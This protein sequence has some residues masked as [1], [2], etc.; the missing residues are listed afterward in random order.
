MT[1]PITEP[2]K[3]GRPK[4][5]KNIRPPKPTRSPL[6][7]TLAKMDVNEYS[8]LEGSFD[9]VRQVQSRC[10]VN[11]SR[12]PPEMHGK[13]FATSVFTAISATDAQEVIYLIRIWRIE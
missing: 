6:Y 2:R 4:G 12:R 11:D 1:Q 7:A 9:E 10:N 8:F 5:R 13:K 3:L